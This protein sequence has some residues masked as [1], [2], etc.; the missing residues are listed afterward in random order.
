MREKERKSYEKYI[1]KK[2]GKLFVKRLA[3]QQVGGKGVLF[4]C[5][6]DCGNITTPRATAV[7]SGKSKTCKCSWK[8]GKGS[9]IP[10]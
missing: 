3:M 1:G 9:P 7:I 4:E 2:F 5:Q 8:D 10:P 6:C